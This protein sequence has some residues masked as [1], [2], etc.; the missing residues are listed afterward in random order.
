MPWVKVTQSQACPLLTET[1]HWP[2]LTAK[3]YLPTETHLF[4]FYLLQPQLSQTTDLKF[5]MFWTFAQA[6]PSAVIPYLAKVF[7]LTSVSYFQVSVQDHVPLIKAPTSGLR[8]PSS[9]KAQNSDL[10]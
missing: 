1:L 8:S 7:S 3:A 4:P 5:I 6:D 2:S 9:M 10:P